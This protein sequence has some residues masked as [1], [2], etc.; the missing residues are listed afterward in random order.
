MVY[1]IKGEL[2]GLVKI[3]KAQNI[4]N[5]LR[6][7]Q[8]ASPDNLTILAVLPNEDSDRVYHQQFDASWVHAEWF[9]PTPKLLAFIK[10]IPESEYKGLCIKIGNSSIAPT[11]PQSPS[12]LKYVP[13]NMG[14][15]WKVWAR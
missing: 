1:F 4:L 5:R 8:A 14:R 10:S 7:L 3:G 12:T 13:P 2:T 11:H 15:A 6:T 9:N